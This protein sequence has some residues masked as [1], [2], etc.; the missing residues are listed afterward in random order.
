MRPLYKEFFTD[1]NKVQRWWIRIPATLMLLLLVIS[2]FA[3]I[4]M[5]QGIVQYAIIEFIIPC[6]KGENI[7][8]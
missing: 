3:I 8:I 4:G 1:L 2:V 5:I 7:I 6:I